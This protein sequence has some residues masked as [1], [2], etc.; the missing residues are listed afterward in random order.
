VIETVYYIEKAI[1]KETQLSLIVNKNVQKKEDA[2]HI[3]YN[4][5]A[6]YGAGLPLTKECVKRPIYVYIYNGPTVLDCG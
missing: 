1:F 3:L 6:Q 4:Q 2:F 5:Y